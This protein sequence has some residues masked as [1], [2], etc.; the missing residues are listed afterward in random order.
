MGVEFKMTNTQKLKAL[1]EN[2]K[3]IEVYANLKELQAQANDENIKIVIALIDKA[4]DLL[5]E[6]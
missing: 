1:T 4:T 5:S 3:L 6:V 2:R